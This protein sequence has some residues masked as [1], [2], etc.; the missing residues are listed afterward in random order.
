MIDQ[1]CRRIIEE[2]DAHIFVET[3]TSEA[4]SLV[5]V[6]GWFSES[7]PAFGKIADYVTTGARSYILGSPLIKYPVFSDVSDSRLKIFSVDIDPHSHQAIRD[8]FKTNVNIQL[9]CGDSAGFLKRFIDKDMFKSGETFFY[10]D[11]HGGR[12]CPLRN[13]LK[14][15]LRLDKSIIV[16]DDFFIPKRSNRMRPHGAFGFD[17]FAGKILDW[18]YIRDLFDNM[19]V[20]VYYLIRSNTQGRGVALLFKGYDSGELEFMKEMPFEY[21]DKDDQVHRDPTPVSLLAY[22]DFRCLA[23]ALLPLPLLKRAN[24]ILQRLFCR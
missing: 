13:E 2:T 19:H 15:I 8:L 11:A 17:I 14:E 10:L 20:R 23:L 7:D 12:R 3:G 4:E 24:R 16:L 18:G 1:S 9:S 6:A 5:E 22:L 21:I